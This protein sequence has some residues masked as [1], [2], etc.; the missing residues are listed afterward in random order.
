MALQDAQNELDLAYRRL[1]GD[2]SEDRKQQKIDKLNAE[3]SK[4]RS[5]NV[6]RHV[7]SNSVAFLTSVDSYKPVQPSF[8]DAKSVT[9]D[10]LFLEIMFLIFK[11]IV[12]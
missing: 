10:H 5:L 3:V 4:Q 11:N 2:G 6:L 12:I 9:F 7:I 8:K 1:Q